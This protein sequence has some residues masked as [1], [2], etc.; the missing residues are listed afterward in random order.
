MSET[1]ATDLGAVTR[2]FEAMGA[3][4]AQAEVMARQL[5]KRSEQLGEARGIS[6]VEAAAILLKQV[7]EARDGRAPSLNS[8]V[9]RKDR[10]KS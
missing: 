10:L 3:S 8:K 2:F 9:K 6:N 5:L 7:V 1:D 4:P